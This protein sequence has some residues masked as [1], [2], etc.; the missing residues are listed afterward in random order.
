MAE[1]YIKDNALQPAALMSRELAAKC[2]ITTT[3]L[4]RP[5]NKGDD[6]S[7][8]VFPYDYYTAPLQILYPDKNSSKTFFIPEVIIY[9][10]PRAA[11]TSTRYPLAFNRA[12]VAYF[13]PALKKAY[14]NAGFIDTRYADTPTHIWTE[15]T[16]YPPDLTKKGAKSD[17]KVEM[18][19]T[20][21]GKRN[22]F[23]YKSIED[24]FVKSSVPAIRAD[25]TCTMKLQAQVTKG[26]SLST[27]A[28]ARPVFTLTG[29][30][31]KGKAEIPQPI[32]NSNQTAVATEQNNADE[33]FWKLMQELNAGSD[34][35][36]DDNKG[37]ASNTNGTNK[38]L[39]EDDDEEEFEDES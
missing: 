27:T 28:M 12:F 8:N 10:L 32:T 36:D 17:L 25:I 5:G 24:F 31:I 7:N 19:M 14:S 35:E 1:V 16:V 37:T 3:A 2:L 20:K 4:K 30:M 38:Y 22:K 11:G 39:E 21:D 15:G 23:T 6:E 34:D 29:V 33:D 13:E 9:N 18:S 26:A